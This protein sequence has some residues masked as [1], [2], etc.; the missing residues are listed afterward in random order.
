[1]YD[2]SGLLAYTG[3]KVAI[4]AGNGLITHTVDSVFLENYSVRISCNIDGVTIQKN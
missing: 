4:N 3:S 2:G 1:L